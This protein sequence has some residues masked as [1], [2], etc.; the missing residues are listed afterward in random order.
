MTKELLKQALVTLEDVNPSLVCEMAHHPKKDQHGIGQ[1]CPLEI[2]HLETIAAI[3]EALAQ[4]PLPAQEQ[5]QAR[6]DVITVNLMREGIDKHRARELA[7]H[8]V[9]FTLTPPLPVQR[10]PLTDEQI[11]VIHFDLCN[12]VGSDYKTVARAIEAAHGIKEQS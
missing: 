12:T 5:Q 10:Q 6:V 7:D 9:N 1:K 3:K 8:F 11:K 2:R 4:P